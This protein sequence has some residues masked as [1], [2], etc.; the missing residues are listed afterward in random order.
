[1]DFT[2][3]A[4]Y[5]ANLDRFKQFLSERMA[6]K[7]SGWYSTGAIPRDFM[8]ELGSS[9]FL[10]YRTENGSVREQPAL[11]QVLLFEHLATLSPGV[12]VAVLVHISLG[13]IGI[14]LFGNK[15]QQDA[16]L[17]A[18]AAGETLICLGNTEPGAGSDV[19]G[20]ASNAE[21]VD[22]GWVLSGTKSYVTNGYMSDLAL[23][24]ALT[25]PKAPRNSRMSMFLVDLSS[26]GTTRTPLNKRVWIPSDL[27]RI[28]LKNVFVPDENLIGSRGR[29]LQQVLEIFTNSRVTISALTLGTAVGAFRAGIEHAQK[30]T[31]FNRK[32]IEFQAKSF[33][34]AD[35]YSRMEAA[36][37]VLWKTS[38]EKDSGRD[39]RLGASISKYLTV[40]LARE[41]G[42][43]AA[44]LFGG[45]SVVFEHPIHKFPMDAWA[46]SLGEGTQDVQKLIIFREMMRREGA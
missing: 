8:R 14:R 6:P 28:Q 37:L 29:G 30:R 17:P 10:G 19:A 3:P 25:D 11:Q 36:R 7:L 23:I 21:K 24:T 34:A 43:W 18:A 16:L 39:F 4:D 13:T 5:I 20:I 15:A 22:G 1:M 31:V 12:G 27:T 35:F 9:G 44:D 42:A 33:E 40:A 32:V 2:L 45:A 26:A 46:S 38:W 41:V